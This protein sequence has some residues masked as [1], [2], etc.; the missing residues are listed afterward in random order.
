VTLVS[1]ARGRF[2]LWL[3]GGY[4]ALVGLAALYLG[5]RLVFAPVSSEFAGMPLLLLSLPWSDWLAPVAAESAIG[6]WLG[7][8]GGV[9]VNAAALLLVGRGLRGARGTR[10]TT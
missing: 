3:P 4:L 2:D 8:V 7:L 5:Y 10:G 1:R 9:I 6:G